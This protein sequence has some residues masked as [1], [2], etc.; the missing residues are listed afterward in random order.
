MRFLILVKSAENSG[1]PPKEM[2]EAIAAMNQKGQQTG[3][4]IASGGLAPSAASTRV[5]V[6]HRTLAVSDGPFTETREVVG[7]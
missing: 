4:M 2:M 3:Q 6:S 1:T 7:G 5:R